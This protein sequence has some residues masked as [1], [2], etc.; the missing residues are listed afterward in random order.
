MLPPAHPQRRLIRRPLELTERIRLRCRIDQELQRIVGSPEKPAPL[1]LDVDHVVKHERQSRVRRHARHAT[2]H[3]T[4]ARSITRKVLRPDHGLFAIAVRPL[5]AGEDLG[6]G[7]VVQAVRVMH[8]ADES[9]LVHQAGHV[10][11]M[12]ADR[13]TRHRGGD[14]PELAPNFPGCIGLGV[15]RVEMT[16]TAVIKNQNAG[17]N[18]SPPGSAFRRP[19]RPE[20]RLFGKRGTCP[21]QAAKI[22]AQTSD[23]ALPQHFAAAPILILPEIF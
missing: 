2:P 11:Q 13:Q 1:A 15:E 19:A 5:P 10:R 16:R 20:R 4:H 3:V 7:R 8:A 12:L 6:R 9:H 18:R 17:P 22:E 23:Q 21:D 14:R